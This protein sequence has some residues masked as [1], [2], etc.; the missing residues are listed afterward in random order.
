MFLLFGFKTTNV[1]EV[2][3]VVYC[4]NDGAELAA[5]ARKREKEFLRFG[6][7]VHPTLLPYRIAHLPALEQE[8]SEPPRRNA[9]K[10]RKRSASP[11][12]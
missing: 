9:S 7:L 12:N 5:A 2:P 3:E 4:G 1:R 8:H 10:L 6:R 11:A